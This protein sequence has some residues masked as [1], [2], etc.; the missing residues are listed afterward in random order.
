[1]RSLES[2]ARTHALLAR[3]EE[4]IGKHVDP[5]AK[6]RA[7][8]SLLDTAAEDGLLG[9]RESSGSGEPRSEF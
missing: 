3:L 5:E 9:G 2:I 7:L 6:T 1:M 8:L 4:A